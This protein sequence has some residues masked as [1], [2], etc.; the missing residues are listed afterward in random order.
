MVFAPAY[1]F[2]GNGTTVVL[3]QATKIKP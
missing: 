3:A 1:H 2:A